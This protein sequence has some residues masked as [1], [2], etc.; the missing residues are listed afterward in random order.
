MKINGEEVNEDGRFSRFELIG[1]WDQH[2]LRDARVL[3]IGAG[4]LGNEIVKN[5]ALIGV[6]NVFIAD[7]DEVENSNLSR[8]IL[9]READNGRP[10]AIAA[11]RAARD[12]YPDI[13][14]Q[15][16]V[17]NVVHELGLGV[18]A[19]ADIIIGGLDNREA[20]V[21][22]N[23]A[24]LYTGRCWIDGAIEVLNGVVRVFGP[25]EGACY[26]CTMSATDWQI[27]QNRRSCALLT[28][29]EMLAGRV[30]T[31]PTTGSIIAGMQVQEAIKHLH[32]LE[33]LLGRGLVY[34]GLT[35]EVY[36]TTYTRKEDCM[37]HETCGRIV[38][39]PQG[40]AD[41]TVGDLLRRIREDLG[42]DASIE[43]S[44]DVITGILCPACGR[45]ENRKQ[46]L[47]SM[48]EKDARCPACKELRVPETTHTL[49]HDLSLA[50]RT[51][52]EVGVP[53]FDMVT[54]YNDTDVISYL[55]MGDAQDVLGA[56][57]T[58][59]TPEEIKG[60]GEPN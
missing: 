36:Q 19:W 30:P 34:N 45:R 54:G 59:W 27:L 51:L 21:A 44:R 49:G 4:A 31:T 22:M 47:G 29:D 12:I 26:E 11:C 37:A 57:A 18:Y 58:G 15:P 9:Y 2:R 55:F 60:A 48:K 20:R 25:G 35:G 24:S 46:V 33:T 3:V 14:A 16:F 43:L 53:K 39:L 1:W 5:L 32:G 41:L 28:R 23:Q 50:S 17:G 10:K 42:G 8:S 7:L 38:A 6:G 40:V 52:S 56:L 13:Q